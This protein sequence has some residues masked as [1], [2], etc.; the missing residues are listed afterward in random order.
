[1]MIEIETIT[2][3]SFS[4]FGEIVA[5]PEGDQS[6]FYIV[7]SDA[8]NPWRLCVFRYRNHTIRRI[9]C[10]PS[11][12]ESFEPLGGVTILLV[13]A[14]EAPEDYHLFLLDH[15]VVL[16]KGVWHQTLSLTPVSEVKIT[17]NLE[18]E[19]VF[20]DLAHEVAVG[21]VTRG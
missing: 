1:M 4:E 21:G 12:K 3:G 19:S 18:V 2:H 7:D 6:N 14:H 10:H 9:E 17:E 15:P 5:F 13:A 11:S 16:K 20:Y 8:G